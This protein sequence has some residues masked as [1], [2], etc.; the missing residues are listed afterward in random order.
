MNE[1]E[2][3]EIKEYQKDL[4]KNLKEINQKIKSIELTLCNT[5]LKNSTKK[6]LFEAKEHLE[7][8]KKD[9]EEKTNIV[10]S[11]QL[12]QNR[13][14]LCNSLKERINELTIKNSKKDKEDLLSTIMWDLNATLDLGLNVKEMENDL[15]AIT[16]TCYV[17]KDN[18][19]ITNKNTKEIE[20]KYLT[21]LDNKEKSLIEEIHTEMNKIEELKNISI[22]EKND[23]DNETNN[24]DI[25]EKKSL[26]E[27][28]KEKLSKVSETLKKSAKPIAK[29]A[30]AVVG[31]T[32]ILVTLKSCSKDNKTTTKRAD[33]EYA[34]IDG[35]NIEYLS[36]YKE[37]DESYNL[38]T[39][40]A[41]DFVNRAHNIQETG[42]LANEDTNKV[43]GVINAIDDQTILKDEESNNL[44]LVVSELTNVYNGYLHDN[45]TEEAINKLNALKEMDKEGTE[46][47][48]FLTKYG[49]EARN[50]F[51][52]PKSTEEKMDI[53]NLLTDYVNGYAGIQNEGLIVTDTQ[54]WA[55]GYVG[56]V[57]PLMSAYIND[58][59]AQNMACLQIDMLSTYEKWAQIN[60][61][62]DEN[63]ILKKVK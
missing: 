56:F 51:N 31:T 20:D 40:E 2:L 50:V 5:E 41:V 11:I 38:T 9:I 47:D 27:R 14:L 13:I 24:E 37:A 12:K 62:E 34:N 54:D 53:Y 61:C 44:Q 39:S 19:R 17:T 43:V 4:R 25:E 23:M 45:Q 63:Q 29:V 16:N 6:D 36:D 22:N 52:N 42:F 26:K 32:L 58:E 57:S 46:L 60:Y 55:T 18:T 21:V 49:E 30:L 48:K 15:K 8:V 1:K 59:N 10:E 33:N 28:T 35:Y 7:F 3:K